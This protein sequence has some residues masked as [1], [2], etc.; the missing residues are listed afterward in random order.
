MREPK[1]DRSKG[2][3]SRS[4]IEDT[5]TGEYWDTKDRRANTDTTF[6]RRDIESLEVSERRKE[7]LRKILRRQ[8]GE[9]PGET[10]VKG[11]KDRTA[12]NRSERNRRTI[13]IVCSQVSFADTQKSRAK[14]LF[15]DVLDLSSFGPYS[16]EQIAIGVAAVVAREHGRSL[17]DEAAFREMG[18]K[19]GIRTDNG[20]FD[21]HTFSN[22]VSLVERRLE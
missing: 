10:Y 13:G 17:E 2:N 11:R 14:H 4:A 22:I 9:N 21:E 19:F 18:A 15:L 20:E 3:G 1:L 8:E 12:Q 16:V 6:F 5:K 7:R